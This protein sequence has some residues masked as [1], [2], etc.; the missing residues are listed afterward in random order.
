M[1]GHIRVFDERAS[2]RNTPVKSLLKK[3]SSTGGRNNQGRITS[4][5]RGGGH[6]RR[7]RLI[8]FKRNKAGVPAKVEAIEYDPNRNSYL[9]RLMYIDGERRYILAPEGLNIGDTVVS[10][11]D[12]EIKTGNATQLSNIPTGSMVHNV[13]LKPGFGG[14]LIRGAGTFGQL[15]AKENGYAFIKMPSGEFRRVL[16]SCMATL[17]Q[18]GNPEFNTMSYGKAGRITWFG[19]KPHNRGVSMNPV[20]H[21]HGG[22]EGRTSGGRNPVSPWAVPTKGYKT[23]KTKR[24][25]KYILKRRK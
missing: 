21:P 18:V 9:A 10:G 11:A 17:G 22:G 13:E 5:F 14:Q 7:Y 25:T 15:L 6:K 4:R 16:L 8:D 3:Q 2:T 19:R 23:R 24:T 12:V 20:D 1:R